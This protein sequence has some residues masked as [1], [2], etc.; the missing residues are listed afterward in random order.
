MVWLLFSRLP[1]DVV[2]FVIV[3]V[4]GRAQT[5]AGKRA[6]CC[7]LLSSS[8]SSAV[9]CANCSAAVGVGVRRRG[10]RRRCWGSWSS[11][12]ARNVAPAAAGAATARAAGPDN[13]HNA[14]GSRHLRSTLLCWPWH[15]RARGLPAVVA[16]G[17]SETPCHVGSDRTSAAV[18]RTGRRRCRP[19]VA[20]SSG[21]REAASPERCSPLQTAPW[22]RRWPAW[23]RWKR[24]GRAPG[25]RSRKGRSGRG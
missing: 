6:A 14:S 22:R 9:H 15:G 2:P 13:K 17:R 23:R 20:T 3:L 11:S 1:L 24:R 21:L 7:L 25:A 5:S 12:W 8:S 18:A 19:A 16:D 4:A 10:G